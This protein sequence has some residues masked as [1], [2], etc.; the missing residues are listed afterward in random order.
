MKKIK[1]DNFLR[2]LITV[3]LCLIIVV[4]LVRRDITIITI[5]YIMSLFLAFIGAKDLYRYYTKKKRLYLAI[6]TLASAFIYMFIA[7]I[8]PSLIKSILFPLWFISLGITLTIQD[9]I[10]KNYLKVLIGILLIAFGIFLFIHPIF[11]ANII[12]IIISLALILYIN[13]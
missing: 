2:R 6:F 8:S 5:F 9:F 13:Y 7:F 3:L 1:L 10:S 12:L 11:T 4:V